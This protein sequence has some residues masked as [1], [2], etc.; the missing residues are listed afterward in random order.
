[1]ERAARVRLVSVF[2]ALGLVGI[3]AAML[4]G[5]G[6]AA[7]AVGLLLYRGTRT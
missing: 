3:G 6:G 1:M 5:P 2:F 4:W 7:L